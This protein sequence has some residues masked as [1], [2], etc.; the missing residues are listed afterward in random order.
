MNPNHVFMATTARAKADKFYTAVAVVHSLVPCFVR[1]GDE[2]WYT[3]EK[4]EGGMR[5]ILW[6]NGEKI[7]DHFVMDFAP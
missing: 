4:E 1:V 6:I 5:T 2:V 7:Q 3:Q